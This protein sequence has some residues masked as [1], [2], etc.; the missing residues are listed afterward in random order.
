MVFHNEDGNPARAN[1]KQ[2]LGRPHKGVKASANSD[3][4]YFF[5]SAQD[6]DPLQ[7][8]VRLCLGDD[9]KKAQDH[10]QRQKLAKSKNRPRVMIYDIPQIALRQTCYAKKILEQFGM[11]Y[12]NSTKSP[13]EPKLKVENDK[14]GEEIDFTEYRRLVRCLRINFEKGSEFKDLV[15]FIDSDCGGDPVSG[16]STCGMIFY[17]GRNAITWQSQ[18]QKTLGIDFMGPFPSLRGN[19]YILVAVDYLSKWVEAKSLPTN[20]ARVVYKFLKSLFA[21]F[22]TPRAII[23]DRDTLI[24]FFIKWFYGSSWQYPKDRPTVISQR[25]IR[26]LRFGI[27]VPLSSQNRRDL[28]RNTP[29][30]RVEVLD[31]PVTR[32]ASAAAK[33]CQGDSFE[34]YLITGSFPDVMLMAQI[35]P[36]D[37]NAETVP[38]YRYKDKKA[39][40]ERENRYLEDIVDL[41]EKLSSHDRIVYKIGYKNP[42]H[43]KKAIA[44]QQ[45]MYDGE[46][47]HSTKLTFVSPD[48]EE[49]L[50]DV[51]ENC[52]VCAHVIRIFIRLEI[53]EPT[54]S[55]TLY[56]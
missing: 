14:G 10:S 11:Q 49:T 25:V 47:L 56:V 20:N 26:R 13:M 15:G 50:E 35:Q 31:A 45:K 16:K 19:K 33:P 55:H 48:L 52:W 22:G 34:F 18:K 40:K 37:G 9:L 54:R 42:E 28:P 30:D 29:L 46:R 41:K 2:A 3:V 44:A 24:D 38:S 8:D 1:I 6:G 53:S 43:L 32:T 5:T 12:C 21:R 51:E 39:F 27:F 17:L 4:M 36:A 7:D 23:S